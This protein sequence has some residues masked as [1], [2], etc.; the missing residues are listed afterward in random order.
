M[1]ELKQIF[2]TEIEKADEDTLTSVYVL[3][4]TF[5]H[6]YGFNRCCNAGIFN[7]MLSRQYDKLPRVNSL[8]NLTNDE[9]SQLWM[10]I[11]E[12]TKDLKDKVSDERRENMNL[13]SA[14]LDLMENLH[15]I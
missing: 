7:C 12:Q 1:E 11:L 10:F 3:R 8:L 5:G 15:E 14:K 6:T 4:E 13:L 2:Q 9:H